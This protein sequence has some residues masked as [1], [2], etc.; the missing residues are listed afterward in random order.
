MGS[1]WISGVTTTIKCLALLHIVH[2][3]Y[4]EFT[5]TRGE[6]M[7]PTLNMN[8]DYVHV[9]KWYRNGRD[10]RM[11]DCIV[12]HKP[13]DARKRVCKRITGMPGDYILVDPSLD[14]TDA[15]TTFIK[16]PMGHVWVT[17]DNLTHSLDSRTY[18][19]VPMGLI[20]GKIVAANDLN[21]PSWDSQKRSLFGFRWIL[22]NFNDI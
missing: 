4:Y 20:E 11:G 16:V 5:Q 9:S 21:K 15:G 8:N 14:D 3:R 22:N 19:A 6:S 18:N 13:N 1:A 17:G 12:L 10:C 2:S 7:L